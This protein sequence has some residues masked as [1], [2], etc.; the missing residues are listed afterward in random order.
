MRS[1]PRHPKTDPG[2]VFAVRITVTVKG[3]AADRADEMIDCL[4]AYRFRMSG[5]PRHA[6]FIGAEAFSLRARRLGE[7][8]TAVGA[9]VIALILRVPRGH[10]VVVGTLA[11]RFDGIHG[12]IERG[13]D[14][15]IAFALAAKRLDPLPLCGVHNDSSNQREKKNPSPSVKQQGGV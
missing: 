5:P 3:G 13:G 6:A 9:F 1:S 12:N 2:A 7:L 8:H 14:S 4:A 10:G 11:E 15:G